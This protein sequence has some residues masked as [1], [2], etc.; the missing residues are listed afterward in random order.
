[1][2]YYERGLGRVVWK[3]VCCVPLEKMRQKGK[4]VMR[5]GL[6]MGGLVR[7]ITWASLFLLPEPPIP[8]A[9][10]RFSPSSFVA[11]H[12]N[13]HY[14]YVSLYIFI[15]FLLHLI[16]LCS[17]SSLGKKETEYINE[18]F[19]ILNIVCIWGWKKLVLDLLHLKRYKW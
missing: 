3:R 6:V 15:Q 16:F 9:S 2:L 4:R 13:S 7:E 5:K 11:S 12:F 17:S 14:R 19:L 1:M 8:I 10:F 18:I